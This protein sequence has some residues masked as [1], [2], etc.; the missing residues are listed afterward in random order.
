MKM[1][2]RF[3]SLLIGCTAMALPAAA[4]SP[5]VGFGVGDRFPEIVLPSLHD[6]ESL[7]MA[8]FRGH[9]VALHVWASW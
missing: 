5:A 8:S 9:K 2:G 6:G 3:A 1:S 7:S 4:D